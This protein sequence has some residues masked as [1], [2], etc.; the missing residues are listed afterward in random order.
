VHPVIAGFSGR[1]IAYPTDDALA[2]QARE[3]AQELSRQDAGARSGNFALAPVPTSIGTPMPAPR[4]R[5]ASGA[6]TSG[7][8]AHLGVVP[9]TTPIVVVAAVSS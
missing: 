9:L 8:F 2:D 5:A 4:R 1:A 3:T 7:T 6:G